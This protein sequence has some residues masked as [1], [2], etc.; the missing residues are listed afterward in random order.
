MSP[1]HSS[2]SP[3]IR[4]IPLLL[5]VAALAY[6][7]LAANVKAPSGPLGWD[8]LNHFLA[9]AVLAAL[10]LFALSARRAIS[11]RSLLVAWFASFGYGLLLELLQWAMA[12]GRCFEL[13]DLFANGFGALVVCLSCVLFR[14]GRRIASQS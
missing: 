3:S 10:L 8:K 2:P 4:L 6:L 9:Y 14:H 11:G 7:S 13:A 12:A 5:W 1:A